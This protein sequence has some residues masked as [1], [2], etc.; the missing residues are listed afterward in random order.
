MFC[1]LLTASHRN[2]WSM[3]QFFARNRRHLLRKCR[4]NFAVACWCQRLVNNTIA[5]KTLNICRMGPC[6]DHTVGSCTNGPRVQSCQFRHAL[7]WSCS[8]PCD[9]TLWQIWPNFVLRDSTRIWAWVIV[10][11]VDCPRQASR[12][13][14]CSTKR[15]E[16]NLACFPWLRILFKLCFLKI[17]SVSKFVIY[18][19]LC[20]EFWVNLATLGYLQYN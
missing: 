3:T 20:T 18:C 8:V 2:I 19:V 1:Q 16:P 13:L 6:S 7:N 11:R 15:W 14:C 5:T 4:F 17:T 12:V 10:K 9:R